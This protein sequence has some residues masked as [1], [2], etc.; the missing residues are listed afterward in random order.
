MQR[1]T[2]TH[3]HTPWHTHTNTHTPAM[4]CV[5]YASSRCMIN[6]VK[7]AHTHTHTHAH[8][9]TDKQLHTHTQL[10]QRVIPF[11]APLTRTVDWL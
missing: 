7:D 2:H 10:Y 5:L 4:P 8:T 1:H 11:T 6:K 9:H 3:T